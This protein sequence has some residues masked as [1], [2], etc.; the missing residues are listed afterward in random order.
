VAAV[1]PPDGYRLAVDLEAFLNEHRGCGKLATGMTEG[2]PP[3]VW[4][5]CSCGARMEHNA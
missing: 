5:A 4:L 2:H 1:E 3:H